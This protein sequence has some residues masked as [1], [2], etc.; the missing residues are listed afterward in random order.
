[1]ATD[2]APNESCLTSG[3][4]SNMRSIKKHKFFA[5]SIIFTD[6][7]AV[8]AS[9]LIAYH[10]RFS[11]FPIPAHKGIPSFEAYLRAMGFVIPIY[12][13]MFRAYQLYKPE[14]HIRRVYELLNVVKAVTGAAIL[15]MAFTFIYREFS[16]SRMVLLFAWFFS[17]LLCVTGR[18][19]LIQFEYFIR[20]RTD[21]DRVVIVGANRNSR[22]LIRWSK[23]NLHYGQDIVGIVTQNGSNEGKHF[24]GIPI[25][26]NLKNV[27]SILQEQQVDEIIVADS[28][29]PRET[30]AD[31]MLKCENRLMSF[32]LVAD[33]YGLM[34]QHVAVDYVSN[35][36]LLGLKTLPLDDLW[37]R[38]VK[39]LFDLAVSFCLLVAFFP[40][41]VL[42]ALTIKLQDRGPCFYKQERVGQDEKHFT[43]YKFRTMSLDAEQKTGPVWALPQD[44]RLTPVGR[45]LRRTNIDE[46]PQ[47]WNVFI[48]R[49]SLVGPR[50][51]RPF[52]VNQ[53]R[54]QI[55]RYMA[56]HK[57]KSGLT[58]WAQI[59][60][61]RGNT[62]LEER[63]KYD[64]YYMENWTLMLDIEILFATCFAFKNAY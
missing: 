38:A 50:P 48:G 13:L 21:R 47:L 4:F 18:Y 32:K 60:G 27:E 16:Y 7:V 52:F 57:I 31:L 6:I 3:E 59:H 43:L 44:R 64:L 45:I 33:F 41:F 55:P 54:D 42:V 62:S 11:G 46:L 49:M 20:R 2:A 9:F 56:R 14:R 39:R 40:I 30:V 25:V 28:T 22:D 58:G 61:L 53:F 37:N 29:L 15:L 26:G 51:E 5:I 1:M 8:L 23:E 63:I 12:L 10:L 17:V 34:T 19:F 35:V 36:P 24:E